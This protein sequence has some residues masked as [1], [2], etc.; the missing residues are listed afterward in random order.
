MCHGTKKELQPVIENIIDKIIS[1]A[2][3]STINTEYVSI[4]YRMFAD[5]VSIAR[6]GAVRIKDI[7]A[8]KMLDKID[9]NLSWS[10]EEKFVLEDTDY[11]RIRNINK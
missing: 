5:L 3:V 11:R 2:H 1:T 9:E 6:C 8:I 7:K 10:E 4:D